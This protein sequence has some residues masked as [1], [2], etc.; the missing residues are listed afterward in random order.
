MMAQTPINIASSFLA[1]R[2]QIA[3]LGAVDAWV[4]AMSA[5]LRPA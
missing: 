4:G 3:S 5:V 2:K 1:K